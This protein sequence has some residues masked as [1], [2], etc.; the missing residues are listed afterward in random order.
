MEKVVVVGGGIAGL[1]ASI[2]LTKS[3]NQVYLIEREESCGGLLRSFQN[4]DGV[5]FDYGTHVLSETR[6]D[7]LDAVLFEDMDERG[8]ETFD[9]LKP[10]NFFQ[11][12]L[13]DR[14]QLIYAPY[15]PEA[16]YYKGL[17]EILHTEPFEK[18]VENLSVYTEKQYGKTFS[19][20]IYRPLMKKLLGCDLEELHQDA[21][22]LFGY[23][24]LIVANAHTSRELK[25]SPFFDG[26][27][28][29]ESFYE[30]ISPMKKYY[31]KD[32]GG[33][34]KWV[35]QLEEKA[36]QLGVNILTSRSVSSVQ[37]NG[38]KISSVTLDN[39]LV[40][41]CDH[42]VW[43]LAPFTLL[44]AAQIKIDSQPPK[45]RNMTLHHFVFNKPFLVR[46]FFV[47]CND[48]NYESFRITLYPNIT[49]TEITTA[50][51]NC[52][53]E[54]LSDKVE[55]LSQLN[56]KIYRELIDLGIVDESAEVIYQKA[57]NIDRGFP[58]YTN[59][60]VEQNQ[61]QKELIAQKMENISL[62]GKGNGVSFFM[63]EVL[64]EA[65]HECNKIG[66]L[67]TV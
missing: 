64:V 10:G 19:N 14:N 57:Q 30:G 66:Q 27:L 39:N 46:N 28:S 26:K 21:H 12:K 58:V 34:G 16:V 18:P 45:F 38:N 55:D 67:E 54:V 23:A 9:I 31:P 3:A 1:V 6:I 2:L 44:Q 53:V 47:Y 42:L 13:Y 49:K 61:F 60:F 22:L 43:T 51:F 37:R 5:N 56:E 4:E 41:E 40:L 65:F 20:Y 8:W 25:K 36:Q 32:R 35:K 50:P 24:R 52:T 11:G 63:H 7:E 29:F 48:V 33:I 59:Q 62:L 15:L 17:T